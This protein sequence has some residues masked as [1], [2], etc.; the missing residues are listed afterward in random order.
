MIRIIHAALALFFV[1]APAA[2]SDV[3]E[4]QI[5]LKAHVQFLASD[6][7]RGRE[8]GTRDFDIAAEYMAAQMMA[9]GLKPGAEKGWFQPVTLTSLKPA[10]KGVWTLTRGDAV[11]PLQFGM[12]FFSTIANGTSEFNAQGKIA[13]AGY[14]IVHPEGKIDDY[15][16]LDVRG[17]IV[18]ILTGTP[19]GLPS[20]VDTYF[21]D[22]DQKARLAAARGARAVILIESERR[23]Q[24]Y[25][26]DVIAP[27]WNRPTESWDQPDGQ[28]STIA[29]R[30]PIIGYVSAIGAEKLFA[31]SKIKWIDVVVA[32]RKQARIP[33]GQLIGTL[34][35]ET[36]V[37]S[38]KYQS[39][40]I[41]GLLEGS[42][43][44]L[45]KEYVVLSAHVDHIGVG[46]GDKGDRIH[47]GAMD[48]AIGNAVMLQ[49]AKAF[50]KSGKAPRRSILFLAL[51]A[52]EQGLLGSEFFTRYPSIPKGSI[53]AN[54]NID[55]PILSYPLEDLVVLGAERSSLG[56]I[57][58]RVA[59][60]QGLAVVPDPTPEEM[61]FVRSDHYSF[62]K[63]G[64]PAISIDTGPG[65]AGAVAQREF[66]DKHYHK[67]SDEIGLIDWKSAERF[68]RFNYAVTRAIADADERP[69]WNKGDFFGTAFDGY[70]AK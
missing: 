61:F 45:K 25:P 2:A 34:S 35:T 29:N 50:H 27:Y 41:I 63:A 13:F 69:R 66:L 52:E 44:R 16:D 21:S 64:I 24:L 3:T 22:E 58:D 54:I 36:K 60:E 65:G 47:N 68:T 12:D 17:K 26:F 19:Q 28:P 9:S 53:V 70:G 43:P 4:E 23:R 39:H 42:D 8:A 67:A 62:V 57:V 40:N 33:T 48:N 56:P 51:T 18:A 7:L 31:G 6:A 32:E 55:M 10:E 37:A 14:G 20:D 15:R 38:K 30:A 46:H 5:A 1:A 49:V 11:I 59:A